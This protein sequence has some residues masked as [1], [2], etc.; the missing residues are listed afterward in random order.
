MKMESK[1]ATVKQQVTSKTNV[2]MVVVGA[3]LA[4]FPEYGIVLGE[5]LTALIMMVAGI[6]LR[7][8]TKEPLSDK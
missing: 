5:E 8:I 7:Q 1:M 2:G 3:I 6:L 4:A